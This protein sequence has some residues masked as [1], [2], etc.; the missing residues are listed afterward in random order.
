MNATIK[1]RAAT[2]AAMTAIH[3]SVCWLSESSG[4]THLVCEEADL[5][6]AVEDSPLTPTRT[7]A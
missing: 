2:P 4:T 7:R 3:S 5:R 1:A 6:E